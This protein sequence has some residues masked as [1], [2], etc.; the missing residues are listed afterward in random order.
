M[1]L[2]QVN[3][4]DFLAI[5]KSIDKG[6]GVI[7]AKDLERFYLDLSGIPVDY[8]FQLLIDRFAVNDEKWLSYSE[9]IEIFKISSSKPEN[10]LSS[11]EYRKDEIVLS[12]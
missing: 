3:K 9:F 6:R 7:E 5:F 4:I 11:S 10:S 8:D 2:N 12:P 1:R